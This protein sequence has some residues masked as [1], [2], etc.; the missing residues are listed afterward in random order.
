MSILVT[1]GSGLVGF[2]L[3]QALADDHEVTVT[4][5]SNPVDEPWA[6][7]RRLDIRDADR[8]DGVVRDVAP[9]AVVHAAAMVDADRA[10]RE[11]DLATAVNVEGTRNVLAASEAVAARVT[12]LS[13]SFVFAGTAEQYV[14]DDDREPVNH[15]GRTKVAAEDAA[16]ESDCRTL[17][18]RLDQPY[19][20]SRPWQTATMVEWVLE[21]LDEE[22]PL[23]VFTD[24]ANNPTY[25]PD[26][27]DMVGGLFEA[28]ETGI[29]HCVG[30]EFVDRFTWARIIAEA[31]GRD[32]DRI[33]PASAADAGVPARRPNAALSNEKVRER[34]GLSLHS[35]EAAL[36]EMTADTPSRC[37]PTG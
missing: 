33:R 6:R 32:P 36:A 11:P 19:G 3:A 9:D 16:I 23:E 37:N 20:W 8:V 35:L 13:S 5:R 4:Y 28:A 25:L 7:A 12:L 18:V 2:R 17:I 21:G 27:V 1:G 15:Y 22:R 10:E 24:W 14:E 29:Y 34:L 26:I 30:D 31:F